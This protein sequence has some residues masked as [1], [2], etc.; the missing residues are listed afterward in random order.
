M[1]KAIE[2]LK[3]PQHKIIAFLKKGRDGLR[4][5]YSALREK[6]RVAENQVR[7]V[8]KSR[9]QWR[10]RAELAEAE[11]RSQKKGISKTRISPVNGPT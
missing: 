3:S 5:K 4:V 11:L 10:E 7:A 8:T 1:T 9:D 2:E 6:F